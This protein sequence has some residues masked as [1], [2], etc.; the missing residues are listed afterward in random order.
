MS[1]QGQNGE[2]PNLGTFKT[3]AAAFDRIDSGSRQEIRLIPEQIEQQGDQTYETACDG[4]GGKSNFNLQRQM[5]VT[6]L[7]RFGL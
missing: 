4:M 7:T 1:Y 5:L 6:R 3:Q 2:T